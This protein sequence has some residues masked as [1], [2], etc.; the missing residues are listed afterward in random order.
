MEP[1]AF[2]ILLAVNAVSFAAL[3]CGKLRPAPRGA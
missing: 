1:F 2:A 3:L